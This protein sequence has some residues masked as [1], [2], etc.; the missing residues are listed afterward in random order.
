MKHPKPLTK[1]EIQHIRHALYMHREYSRSSERLCRERGSSEA[2][3]HSA[4]INFSLKLDDKLN[5]ME[6]AADR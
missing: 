2:Q 1:D 6:N 3:C 4:R 5:D